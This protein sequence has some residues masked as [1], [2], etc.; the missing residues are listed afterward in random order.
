MY[1]NISMV[2]IPIQLAEAIEKSECDDFVA[3]AT[4]V[5]DLRT[6]RISYTG[7]IPPAENPE[8]RHGKCGHLNRWGHRDFIPLRSKEKFFHP[9]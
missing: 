7:I 4:S 3:D 8:S 6:L 9:K 2:Y 1:R 5:P